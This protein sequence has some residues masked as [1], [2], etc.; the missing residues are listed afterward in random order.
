MLSYL[1]VWG[2]N[3]TD[4]PCYLKLCPWIPK[5]LANQ[6][7]TLVPAAN[8]LGYWVP[9]IHFIILSAY[10]HSVLSIFFIQGNLIMLIFQ[11]SCC[12]NIS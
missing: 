6:P 3:P 12:N 2:Y 11:G 4:W 1:N 5:T 7:N 8:N 9:T 10:T